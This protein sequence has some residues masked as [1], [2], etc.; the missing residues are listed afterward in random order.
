M[1]ITKLR[2]RPVVTAV[3]TA[4]N[5]LLFFICELRGGS[6]NSQVMRQMGAMI[7]PSP[8]SVRACLRLFTS[9]F[10]HFGFTHLMNNMVSLFVMGSFLEERTGHIRFLVIYLA[11]GLAGN[12]VSWYWYASRGEAVISAGASGAISALLGAAAAMTLLRKKEMRGVS[13]PR[14]LIAAALVVAPRPDAGIDLAAHAGGLAAGTLLMLLS[15]HLRSF[16]RY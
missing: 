4:A 2:K 12:L 13:I 8:V 7:I 16:F 9:L 11:G 10:L 15:E 6:G 14:V 1:N 3:L 5:I